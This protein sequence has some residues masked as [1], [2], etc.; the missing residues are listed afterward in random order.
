MRIA[1]IDKEACKPQACGG[2]LCARVCPVNRAGKECILDTEPKA[3]INAELC[4]GCGICVNKCP[5]EAITIVNLPEEL[6]EQ[7]L[8]QYG[9]NDFKIYRAPIPIPK[10]VV[11]LIGQNGTG[12][13]TALKSL[14]GDLAPNLGMDHEATSEE[15]SKFFA[16]SELQGY[17]ADIENKKMAYK[18]QY[19][20]KIPKLFKGTVKKLLEKADERGVVKEL[21]SDFGLEPCLDTDITEVSGGELQKAAI[22]ATIAKKAD[23]YF[24]DEPSS[25]LDVRERL[26]VARAIRKLAQEKLVMIVEHDLIVLDYLA[27]LVHIFYGKPAAYGIVS[28]PKGARMG[29]NEYLDGFMKEE[30]VRFREMPVK[31]LIKTAKEAVE[32]YTLVS[33][34]GIKKKFEKFSLEIEEGEIRNKEI[35]GVLGPNGIGKTTFMK[36]LAGVLEADEGEVSQEVK[37]SYKPQYI[38]VD[39]DN[40]VRLVLKDT[41]KKMIADL[42]LEKL[43]DKNL[44]QLSGGEMQ[45]VAVAECLSRESDIYLLDEP[46][47]HLDVEQRVNVAN[48]LKKSIE[49]KEKAAIVVDHDIMFL[50]YLSDRLMVFLGESGKHGTGK[51]PFSM[52]KG[53]NLFLKDLDITFRRDPDT[54]RPRA[55]K[56]A[57]VKDR[58]QKQVGEYYYTK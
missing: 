33:F 53:M 46:S 38:K 44:S 6:K 54:G 7:C 23:I 15:L 28:F 2:Y 35:V 11:G 13:T 39:Q 43:L 32:T 52:H 24:F 57:S 56:E 27:D 29:I 16:G 40:M 51:G 47:A 48:I 10:Q 5:F 26:K 50:D 20:D 36:I 42:G 14:S 58:E 4:I 17:F 25:Y 30:N 49:E 19:V 45:R 12:K 18:P 1:V 3:A 41:P 9:E 21:I 8:H 37:I 55:N 34:K 22:A 31:F